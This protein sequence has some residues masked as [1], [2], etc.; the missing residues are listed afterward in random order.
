MP[1]INPLEIIWNIIIQTGS[2]VTALYSIV[3][4]EWFEVPGVSGFSIWNM[5]IN[6]VTFILLLL[7]VFVK[8][9]TPA[10]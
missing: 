7:A 10:L 8:K 5:M 4:V 2:W 1:G 9:V 3:F 6:P